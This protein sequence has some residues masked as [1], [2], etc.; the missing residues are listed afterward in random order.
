MINETGLGASDRG[1]RRRTC[2]C[3]FVRRKGSSRDESE[4]C[5]IH[6]L[7]ASLSVNYIVYT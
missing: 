7:S 4:F 1:G 5:R 2:D 3:V 6:F